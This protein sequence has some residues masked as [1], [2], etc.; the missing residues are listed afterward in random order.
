LVADY[1]VSVPTLPIACLATEFTD[2]AAQLTEHPLQT[3]NSGAILAG[4]YP[5]RRLRWMFY[6]RGAHEATLYLNQPT[7][8]RSIPTQ[9]PPQ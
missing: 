2:L 6:K 7:Y 5:L 3:F 4:D 8:A 1:G 9:N